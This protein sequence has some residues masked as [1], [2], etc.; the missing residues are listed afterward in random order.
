M[1]GK[2][3]DRADPHR[4]GVGRQGSRACEGFTPALAGRPVPVQ[5]QAAFTGPASLTVPTAP[6]P[7]IAPGHLIT[8]DPDGRAPPGPTATSAAFLQAVCPALTVA[9]GA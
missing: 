1:A 5:A 2:A 4:Q 8:S 9:L 6:R 7:R 3:N